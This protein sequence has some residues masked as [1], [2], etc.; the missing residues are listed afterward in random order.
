MFYVFMLRK[1]DSNG[2]A[3]ALDFDEYDQKD[4]A[5]PLH[6]LLDKEVWALSLTQGENLLNTYNKSQIGKD[7]IV[8]YTAP[9]CKGWFSIKFELGKYA[10]ATTK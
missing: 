8:I 10:A 2:C 3:L 1:Q 5:V 9:G 4:N 6:I 7:V